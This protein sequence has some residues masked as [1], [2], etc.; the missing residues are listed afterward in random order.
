[1]DILSSACSSF[2]SFLISSTTAHIFVP[3]SNDK[4]DKFRKKSVVYFELLLHCSL[5]S[6]LR[7]DGWY[8]QD[9]RSLGLNKYK[10]GVPTISQQI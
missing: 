10:A 3:N 8:P 5:E 9:I 2:Y 4:F 1:M 6:K 7:Q